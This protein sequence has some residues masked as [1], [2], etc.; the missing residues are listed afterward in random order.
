M[1]LPRAS[2]S[3]LSGKSVS[4]TFPKPSFDFEIYLD[5]VRTE[6]YR[7]QDGLVTVTLPLRNGKVEIKPAAV[8]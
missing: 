3:G 4:F 5:G 1:R 2:G 7:T 8:Q 6:D